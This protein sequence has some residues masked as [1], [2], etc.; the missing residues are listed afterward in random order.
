MKENITVVHLS[1]RS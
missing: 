1:Q